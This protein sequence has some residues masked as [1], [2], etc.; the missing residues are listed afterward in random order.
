MATEAVGTEALPR[1]GHEQDGSLRL[2]VRVRSS[3]LSSRAVLWSVGLVAL[4]SAVTFVFGGVSQAS[5]SRAA[6]PG[7]RTDSRV[8]HDYD[9]YVQDG[10]R[11]CRWETPQQGTAQ[12]AVCGDD[13][14][15]VRVVF[16]GDRV[17]EY[18]V[19]VHPDPTYAT[20][21]AFAPG[22]AFRPPTPSVP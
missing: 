22:R 17:T 4:T 1:R 9:V 20:P 14:E 5:L 8:R 15:S 19:H 18:R 12:V 13:R 16:D 11:G 2:P 10:R 3:G 21:T 7:G 6:P